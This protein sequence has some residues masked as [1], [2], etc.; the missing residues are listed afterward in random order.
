MTS[1][2][3]LTDSPPEEGSEIDT[4]D[5]D[6]CIHISATD[7]FKIAIA[8][9]KDKPT[10][11]KA[12]QVKAERDNISRKISASKKREQ[13]QKAVVKRGEISRQLRAEKEAKKKAR[14]DAK[15]KKLDDKIMKEAEKQ[16][17]F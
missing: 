16:V 2:F 7:K 13:D 9:P 3:E 5:V 10:M 17:V 12:A 8:P 14:A 11:K 15:R 1:K 6:D 4:D